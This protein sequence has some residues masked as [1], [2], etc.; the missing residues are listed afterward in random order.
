MLLVCVVEEEEG[1]VGEVLVVGLVG[2]AAVVEEEEVVA[3]AGSILMALDRILSLA[4]IFEHMYMEY[5]SKNIWYMSVCI[6]KTEDTCIRIWYIYKLVYRKDTK[7]NTH[8]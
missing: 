7:D 5:M 3:A 2:S 1:S 6:Y 4:Y 8:T